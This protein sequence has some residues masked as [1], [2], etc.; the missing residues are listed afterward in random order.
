MV[1]S[2]NTMEVTTKIPPAR[3][4]RALEVGYDNLIP[5]IIVPKAIWNVELIEGDGGPGSIKKI[6]FGEGSQVKSVKHKIQAID[7]K[8]FSFNY[9][10]VEG[11]A[12]MNNLEK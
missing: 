12:L 6:T 4:F 1:V 10:V 2:I 3:M 9:S 8:D 11:G 5:R 7:E